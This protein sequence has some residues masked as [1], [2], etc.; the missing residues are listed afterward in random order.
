MASGARTLATK[1]IAVVII[2]AL[3]DAVGVPPVIMMM[4]TGAV[5][6]VWLC[7]RHAQSREVE[8]LFDFYIAADSILREEERR[9][10]AFEISEVI[11]EG[12]RTLESMD[13][14]PP[15]HLF[16]LGSLYHRLGDY[17]SAVEY[18]SRLVDDEHN[19]ELQRAVPSPQ[20]RRYVSTLRRIEDEP[21]IAPQSLA[22][23]RNL[24]RAR[25]KH[26]RDLLLESRDRLAGDKQIEELVTAMS[27]TKTKSPETAEPSEPKPLSA[28]PPISEVL[29]NVYDDQSPSN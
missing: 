6:V 23:V 17:K 15:L 14:P 27:D 21:S 1:V 11:A 8:R 29:H 3:L 28:P 4:V 20:L 19:D 25:R 12:E 24:E 16:V 18:F 26:A 5:M 9:W 2:V 13:D 22:A 7:T 10:Y